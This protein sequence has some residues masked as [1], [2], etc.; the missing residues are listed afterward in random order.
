MYPELDG[1]SEVEFFTCLYDRI[2]HGYDL[3][4]PVKLYLIDSEHPSHRSEVE[5]SLKELS[6]GYDVVKTKNPNDQ[7]LKIS[8]SVIDYTYQHALDEII[9]VSGDHDL[10]LL[11]LILKQSSKREAHWEV[12]K[13]GGPYGISKPLRSEGI[14]VRNLEVMLFPSIVNLNPY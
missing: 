1:I 9:L 2:T 12:W 4:E 14:L 3:A 6:F 10:G 7:L 8:T 13:F 11:L 5:E